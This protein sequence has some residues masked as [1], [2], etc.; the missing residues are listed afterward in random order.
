MKS[1]L[2]SK[3]HLW[4]Q[5]NSFGAAGGIEKCHREGSWVYIEILAPLPTGL[6]PLTS[7][8]PTSNFHFLTCQTWTVPLRRIILTLNETMYKAFSTQQGLNNNYLSLQFYH[9]WYFI[10]TSDIFVSGKIKNYSIQNPY[11]F[12]KKA[13]VIW[14]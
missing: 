10:I 11:L 5:G 6:L 14:V 3:C 2:K 13:W 8:L 1:Y 9:N 12:F 4:H 7:H